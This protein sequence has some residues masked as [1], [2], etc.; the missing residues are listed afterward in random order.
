[1]LSIFI[2]RRMISTLFLQS[3]VSA[4]LTLSTKK[5]WII[6]LIVDLHADVIRVSVQWGRDL[7][8]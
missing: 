6:L 4:T 7:I 8:R 5:Y 1:M 3:K 2:A